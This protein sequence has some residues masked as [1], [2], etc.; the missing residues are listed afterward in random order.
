MNGFLRRGLFIASATALLAAAT[1]APSLADGPDRLDI[2]ATRYGQRVA[3]EA[4]ARFRANG[5]QDAPIRVVRYRNSGIVVAMPASHRPADVEVS[6]DGAVRVASD[7]LARAVRP[8]T[9]VTALAAPY[10]QQVGTTR[11]YHTIAKTPMGK[12]GGFMD[13]CFRLHKVINDA[14]SY[15][16]YWDISAWA[17]VD[18]TA[19]HAIGDY[20]WIHVDRDGGP[21]F[22]WEDWNPRT[23]RSGN[24]NDISL[25]VS[26]AG[27]GLPLPGITVCETWTLTKYA[28]AGELKNQWNG[29]SQG[30]REVALMSAIHV[31]Q[32]AGT[33]VWGVS[34]YSKILC[35]SGTNCGT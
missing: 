26:A 4:R 15:W 35:Y 34:W 29:N 27:V 3:A 14:D 18:A 9:D 21:T 25:S 20:A 7:A 12:D 23:D 13:T 5:A 16:D 28:A 1:P 31:R 10:W 32:G 11:C 17:T 30:A 2:T 19:V 8:T 24:C 33:P 22:H 6:E